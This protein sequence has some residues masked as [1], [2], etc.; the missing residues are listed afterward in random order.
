MKHFIVRRLV[1]MSAKQM[2]K[3]GFVLDDS[4]DKADGIQ[5]YILSLGS[6]FSGE[7]NEVHYLVGQTTRQDV[8]GVHSLSRNI[9]VRFNHN[10]MSMPLPTSRLRLKSFL[11]NQDFDIIHVQLPYSPWLGH[12]IIESVQKRT[13]VFGTFHIVGHSR[14]VTLATHALAVWTRKSIVRFDRIVSVSSAAA[15][16]AQQTY[17]IMSDVVPNV[18]DFQRFA[19][20]HPLPQYDD[21]VMTILFLGRLVKRKGCLQLLK[22]IAIVQAESG[23]PQY[24]VLIC[25]K[26]PLDAKLR[27]YCRQHGLDRL[28][29]FVGYVSEENKPRY[30]ASADISVFPSTGGES[31]GIVLAEALATGRSVVLAGDNAGYRTVME[32]RQDLLFDPYDTTLLAKKISKFLRDNRARTEA[33]NWGKNYARHYDTRVVGRRLLEDYALALHKRQLL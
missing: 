4:L 28:V 7:G 25:G 15:T 26:G 13:V 12:R 19:D 11:T 8:A 31:F 6:W 23:L 30:Y 14:L 22:A 32:P 24:R 17:G 9:Q 27:N 16:Y 2:L 20:A 10:V 18:V 21:N 1:I 29:T 33:A 5:Q 3:I